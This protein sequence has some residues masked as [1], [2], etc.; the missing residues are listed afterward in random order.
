[1]TNKIEM[2]KTY[3]S[4]DGRAVRVLCV[5][6]KAIRVGG[7]SVVALVSNED[8][9]EDS[10]ILHSDGRYW[11]TLGDSEYDIFEHSPWEDVKVD[12]KIYVRDEATDEWVPRHFAF[13]DKTECRV[14]AFCHGES[15]FT[16][17]GAGEHVSWVFAKLA[18]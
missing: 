1:M 14:N 2:G 8:G 16:S 7:E 3:K 15:S 13:Y 10:V 4:R 12:T 9:Y 17:S 18:E 6:R 11:G 5:D